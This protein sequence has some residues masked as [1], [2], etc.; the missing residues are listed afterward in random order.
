MPAPTFVS[1][2]S[3]TTTT[4]STSLAIA[5]P[6]SVATGLLQIAIVGTSSGSA[7][8]ATPAGWTLLQSLETTSPTTPD[9]GGTTF[10]GIWY[11]TTVTASTTWTLSS[12]RVALGVRLLYSG[13]SAVPTLFS[14]VQ[15]DATTSH[16]TPSITP[17]VNPSVVIGALHVDMN[18]TVTATTPGTWTSRFNG[19]G[20]T[21]AEYQR[22]AV[23]DIVAGTVAT[24]GTFTSSIVEEAAMMSIVIP[25]VPD[26]RGLF[27]PF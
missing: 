7:T 1:V 21:S 15:T 13:H 5:A 9:R 19:N 11:S 27:L 2:A 20:G 26:N 4:A 3:G 25:G 16:P 18:G 23:A 8:L 24:T 22:L 6:A 14:M 17:T 10:T 12:S